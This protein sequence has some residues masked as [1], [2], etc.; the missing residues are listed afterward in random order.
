MHLS[1]RRAG[2]L[3]RRLLATGLL[4]VATASLTAG[5]ALADDHLFTAI[6]ASGLTTSSQPFL[7]GTDN[8]G[9]PGTTVPGQGSPL[10]GFDNTVPAVGTDR[11][12]QANGQAITVIDANTQ[13]PPP[14]IDGTTAPSANSTH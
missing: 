14:V 7:N 13:Q 5:S 4:T 6:G 12:T 3:A 11:L 1:R 9:R 2:T 8:A 10:S